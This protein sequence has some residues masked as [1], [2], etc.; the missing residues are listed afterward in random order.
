[1]RFPPL[2]PAR[3]EDLIIA[4]INMRTDTGL[5]I[6]LPLEEVFTPAILEQLP[7]GARYGYKS[8]RGTATIKTETGGGG[9]GGTEAVY[10]DGGRK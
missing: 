8:M 5:Y 9:G 6:N 1:M 10:T 2:D 3:L 4:V 7:H